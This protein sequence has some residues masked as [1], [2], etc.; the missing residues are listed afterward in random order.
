MYNDQLNYDL[1]YV[2]LIYKNEFSNLVS[3]TRLLAF[4]P[5]NT[6]LIVPISFH[7]EVKGMMR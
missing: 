1:S 3:Y 5:K 7:Q 6:V 2:S 4:M